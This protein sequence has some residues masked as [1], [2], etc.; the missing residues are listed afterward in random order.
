MREVS[1][2]MLGLSGKTKHFQL[3]QRPKRS[4]LSD[5]HYISDNRIKD[6]IDKQRKIFDSTTIS[7]FKGLLKCFGRKPKNGKRKGGIKIYTV[8][9]LSG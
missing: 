6:V 9:L 3:D 1:D 4:T 7:L 5:G 8:T 2:A